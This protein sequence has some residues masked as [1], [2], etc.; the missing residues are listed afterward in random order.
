MTETLTDRL[1]A[2]VGASHVSTDPMTCSTAQR[3]PP[4]VTGAAGVLVRPG[5]DEDVAA[6]L[7][8][9]RDAGVYVTVQGGRT[10][11]VAGTVPGH[12]DVLLS[13][14]RLSDIGEVDVVERRA[15]A[16]AGPRWPRCNAR[17]PPRVWC[18]A[19]TWPHGIRRPSAARHRPT[20]GGLRTV[21]YGNMGEQVLGLDVAL[22]DGSLVRRHS[23]VRSDSTGYDLASLFV[24]A[25]GTLGVITGLDLRLHPTPAHRS[26]PL[27]GSPTSA[28]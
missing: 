4:A 24:G 8:I 23:E 3:R 15:H 12:D 21:R 25:E 22:P 14:E 10:S 1:A 28:R 18:S 13:S 17:R 19:S 2:I 6:V 11:L 26:P 9:C 20:H 16:G 7:R 5:S 27:A